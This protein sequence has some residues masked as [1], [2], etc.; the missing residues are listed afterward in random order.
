[1]SVEGFCGVFIPGWVGAGNWQRL[2]T[3]IDGVRG[4]GSCK[5]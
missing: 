1:M 3:S 5:V 2:V 4:L